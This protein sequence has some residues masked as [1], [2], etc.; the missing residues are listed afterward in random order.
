MAQYVYD[1]NTKNIRK[2]GGLHDYWTHNY[3][4]L[5][6]AHCNNQYAPTLLIDNINSDS[7]LSAEIDTFTNIIFYNINFN[8]NISI[9]SKALRANIKYLQFNRCTFSDYIIMGEFHQLNSIIYKN[10]QFNGHLSI[11]QKSKIN[12]FDAQYSIIRKLKI[13]HGDFATVNI[14]HN[15]IQND[16]AYN[17]LN[18]DKLDLSHNYI[19]GIFRVPPNIKKINLS[20]N[21]ANSICFPNNS[22]LEDLDASHNNIS[23]LSGY[24]PRLKVI[25]LSY[26][27]LKNVPANLN[28]VQILNINY[29]RIKNMIF[30]SKAKYILADP[31]MNYSKIIGCSRYKIDEIDRISWIVKDKN[32]KKDFVMVPRY[33]NCNIATGKSTFYITRTGCTPA[34]RRHINGSITGFWLAEKNNRIFIM[35][36]SYNKCRNIPGN[37]FG[38]YCVCGA[39]IGRIIYSHLDN[40][41]NQCGLSFPQYITWKSHFI[42]TILPCLR[43]ELV[44]FGC[45]RDIY[46]LLTEFCI[47]DIFQ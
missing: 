8:S 35:V 1:G 4:I 28:H 39:K 34:I 32:L 25:N 42:D 47:E 7:I 44:K 46:K 2:Y 23:A 43:S 16:S 21:Y 27:K 6:R 31:Y 37:A 11:H 10:C 22:V 30:P 33:N 20:Y 3:N 38:E 41:C 12:L 45:Y 19:S 9:F 24:A 17:N 5:F 14:A 18:V 13:L 15:N 26:N 40:E 29:N 36:P